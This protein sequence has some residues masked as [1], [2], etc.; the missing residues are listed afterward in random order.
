MRCVTSC[1]QHTLVL[2]MVVL[3]PRIYIGYLADTPA[4]YAQSISQI[5][6]HYEEHHAMRERARVSVTRFSD[7]VFGERF[8]Q[9][10]ARTVA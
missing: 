4:E 2:T 1:V 10:L 3:L 7:E 5:L 6:D 9:E 8:A